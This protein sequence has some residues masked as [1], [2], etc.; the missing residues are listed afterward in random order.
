MSNRP[1]TGN[2][3]GYENCAWGGIEREADD[4]GAFTPITSNFR[5]LDFAV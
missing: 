4:G 2:V 3:D 5:R 1:V